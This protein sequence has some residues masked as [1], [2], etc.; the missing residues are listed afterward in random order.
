MEIIG[1]DLLIDKNLKA[2]LLEI[3]TSP[4]LNIYFEL[5]QSDP[6]I[7]KIEPTEY[8]I[9]PVDLY[10]KSKLVRDTFLLASSGQ[11]R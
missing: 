9:C 8:D 1:F 3:N 5:D 2:W 7:E 6:R 11:L 10:V 4:S